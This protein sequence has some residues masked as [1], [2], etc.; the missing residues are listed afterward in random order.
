MSKE[1]IEDLCGNLP[2]QKKENRSKDIFI[3]PP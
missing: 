1:I 3:Y 2:I